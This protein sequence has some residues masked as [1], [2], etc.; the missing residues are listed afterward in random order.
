MADQNSEVVMQQVQAELANAYAQEF[1]TVRLPPDFRAPRS[2]A[3][4][5]YAPAISPR[6]AR[7]SLRQP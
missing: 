5:A 6:A 1:F 4:S 2:S 3:H 7:P